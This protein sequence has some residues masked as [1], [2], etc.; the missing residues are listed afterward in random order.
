MADGEQEREGVVTT[1][2]VD[3]LLRRLS[4]TQAAVLSRRGGYFGPRSRLTRGSNPQTWK[5]LAR[6]GIAEWTYRGG[7]GG[8]SLTETGAAAA[9]ELR[10][11]YEALDRGEEGGDR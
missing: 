1:G 8:W 3:K 11:R 4:N 9:A 5:S 10:R 7:C 2:T 6:L